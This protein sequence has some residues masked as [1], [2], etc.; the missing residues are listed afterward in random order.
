MSSFSF[1]LR[2]Q[3]EIDQEL[4]ER[5]LAY[6]PH[7]ADGEWHAVVRMPHEI[8][9]WEGMAVPLFEGDTERLAWEQK[10]RGVR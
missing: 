9:E 1:D 10:V 6:D 3:H 8:V 4:A 5:D 2:P 7:G